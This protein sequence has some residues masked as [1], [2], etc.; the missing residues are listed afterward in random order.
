MTFK[1]LPTSL[2]DYVS[3]TFAEDD[4]TPWI[5]W[6]TTSVST[7]R[8]FL[9]VMDYLGL[10]NLSSVNRQP[11]ERGDSK[12]MQYTFEM[13]KSDKNLV[14]DNFKKLI[15]EYSEQSKL[16][17]VNW[18]EGD[19]PIGW[20]LLWPIDDYLRNLSEE[21]LLN[22]TSLRR[23]IVD[24]DWK[25]RKSHQ[26]LLLY[27]HGEDY[28]IIINT[29]FGEF[30]WDEVFI[31]PWFREWSET[32]LLFSLGNLSKLGTYPP[33]LNYPNAFV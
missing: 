6:D 29:Y 17:S 30:Q 25:F 16:W 3:G 2:D 1:D 5:P 28:K 7:R 19:R 9:L 26:P 20:Y 31:N 24:N 15:L 14:L 13:S 18:S 23:L 10:S 21:V 33:S 11:N 8:N 12:R 32:Y 27:N 4:V 22:Y